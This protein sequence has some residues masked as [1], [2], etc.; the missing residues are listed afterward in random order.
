MAQ[1]DTSRGFTAAVDPD[2]AR[3]LTLFDDLLA[4]VLLEQEGQSAVAVLD[5]LRELS[6]SGREHG[7]LQDDVE[8]RAAVAALDPHGRDLALRAFTLH[9]QLMNLAE[10]HHRLRRRRRTSRPRETLSQ[11][12]ADLRARGL[13]ADQLRGLAEQISVRL[14]LTA[15]PTEA[16]RRT[17]LAAQVRLADQLERLDAPWLSDADRESARDSIAGDIELLWQTD[18]VRSTRPS[19]DDEIRHTLW[20][21]ETSLLEASA[22]V[23]EA[24]EREF[25]G[26]PLPLRFGSWVGGDRD[27]NPY[28]KDEHLAVALGRA[29]Q[30]ALKSFRE[31]ARNL[32]RALGMSSALAGAS[33]ELSESIERDERQL[34]W[35]AREVGERNRSEPYRR[36]LTAI[37]RRLDNELVGRDEPGYADE[38]EFRR[39]LD[40]IDA[41]LRGHRGTRIADT[42]L[43]RMRRQA[44]IFGLHL[45]QLDVRV[46]ARDLAG[47]ELAATLEAIAAAQARFGSEAVRRMIISGVESAADIAA[48][49]TATAGYELAIVPLFESIDAL[50]AA[51]AILEEALADPEFGDRAIRILGAVTVMVGYSDSG[52]D[53]GIL[54]AQWEISKA[55]ERLADLGRRLDTPIRF[56]HGRGGSVGRGGGP[57]H[58]AILAQPPAY[59]PGQIELTEQGETIS[60]TYGLEALAAR[61]LESVV[62]ATLEAAH[63]RADARHSPQQRALL[64]RLSVSASGAYR[65]LLDDPALPSFVREFTP[66]EEL[67]LVRIG[68]R[69]AR[70][71]QD[72]DLRALRAIP[73]V[74]SWTQ[75]RMLVPAWY[76]VG[77]ALAPALHDL[78]TRRELRDL[79]AGSPF[80]RSLLNNVEMALAKSS[81]RVAGLYRT[82]VHHPEGGRIFE[83]LEQECDLARAAVLEIGQT[84]ELLDR[85]PAVQRAIHLRNPDVDP[86]NALQVELLQR[87]RDPD[88]SDAARLELERPLARSIAGIAAALRNTG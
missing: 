10:Q 23:A 84:R 86:I 30:L 39:D 65:E 87:W 83:R 63:P 21:F 38:Q 74:F 49:T 80:F 5:R 18:E 11:A 33:P 2:L 54:T 79:Y 20:F 60:F 48:A 40:L 7:W 29:R 9:F 69:P 17:V 52:K 70:R 56:F 62:A 76:G 19:V 12:V 82:L 58:A 25:P 26:V 57:T 15:H 72:P 1:P 51:P 16:A 22:D 3:D 45:G 59:P 85:H 71:S 14:V 34:P 81:L 61:N 43:A 77:T 24:W 13:D 37:H 6:R 8:L 31:Q 28:V 67:S 27:G 35:V 53:G 73:W 75:T 42:K 88:L 47:P 50:Q 32:T 68:S 66:L 78:G 41:S 44:Q 4:R 36:K 64:E 46:H 55:Q